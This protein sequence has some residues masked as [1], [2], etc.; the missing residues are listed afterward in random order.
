MLP[1]VENFKNLKYLSFSCKIED[2]ER[3]Y[4]VIFKHLK[5]QLQSSARN[6]LQIKIGNMYLNHRKQIRKP[7]IQYR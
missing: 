4:F 5:K 3:C 6:L 7:Q 2:F 1:W